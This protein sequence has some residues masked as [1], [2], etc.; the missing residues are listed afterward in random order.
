MKTDRLYPPPLVGAWRWG[1]PMRYGTPA[2][3][4]ARKH[5]YASAAE[6]RQ[7]ARTLEHK[8]RLP[9]KWYHCPNCKQYHVAHEMP[10]KRLRDWRNDNV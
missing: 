10:L 4:C 6:A 1:E 7:A 8:D 2:E 3:Y 9:M 5:A